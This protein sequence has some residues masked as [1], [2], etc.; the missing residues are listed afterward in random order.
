MAFAPDELAEDNR[1]SHYIN[2]YARLREGVAFER[3][4][5]E[6]EQI[7][8][9]IAAAHPD[10]NRGWTARAVPMLEAA[11]GTQ[12]GALFTLL[13]AVG[14]L[15][16][17]AC[18][19]VA[20]LLLARATSRLREFSLRA[21]LGAAP[22]RIVRQLLAESLLLA[23]LGG[24]LGVLLAHWG[25]DALLALAP[26]GMPRLPGARVD[27]AVLGAVTAV[28]LLC[29]IGFGLVPALQAARANLVEA[30]KDGARGTGEGAGR[31]SLRSALVVSEVALALT[32]L[33][34]SGLL[35]R[36]FTR[37]MTADPGFDPRGA[38]SLAVSLSPGRYDT[39]EKQQ[40]FAA[41][42]LARFA[43]LPG[44]TSAGLVQSQ[45]FTGS[46]WAFGI[47]IEGRPPVPDADLRA[48]GYYAIEGDY[49]R[50]MGMPLRRGRA[51]TAQDRAGA[52]PVAIISQT[53][54]DLEFPG[55]NPLGKR[56][57]ITN[58]N[59]PVWREV[60]GVVPDVKQSALDAAPAAQ[61]YEPFA[62][63]S[64]GSLNFVLRT[65]GA[66]ANLAAQL[67]QEIYAIDKDQPVT[68]VTPLDELIAGSLAR[69]RFLTA[70]LGLFSAL[71][72]LLA[73]IGIY[74]VVAYNVGQRT[75]EFGVRLALGALPGDVLRLVLA[76]CAR[77][78]GLG[79][80]AGLALALAAGRLLSAELYQT[81][82]YDP[83]V[84]AAI[85]GLLTLVA[86]LACLL[87]ARRATRV[88]PMQA[89][90][91]E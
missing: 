18:V 81:K 63:R 5:R 30:L 65:A 16:L 49:F 19:N 87:P 31:G 3:G 43:A 69:Q 32:L 57:N 11:V 33:V 14:A 58:G 4:A 76:R 55:E 74:G 13:G 24:G 8:A 52:P 9:Q 40:A 25:L 23:V 67:K 91:S 50:A 36:S 68:R 48:A 34:V 10:S 80:A 42:A 83:L 61:I 6:I 70:L 41:A 22:A 62:Q 29:G 73:A 12:R 45:P 38:V 89:L 2:V 21:A 17:I 37:L 44:V 77:L 1:G 72:L 39:P 15:L 90:R 27:G 66:P 71:A 7:S 54:A 51:F 26:A 84:F 86:L 53:L 85:A 46:E 60:V 78:I 59:A 75:A 35:M 47:A 82:S 79:L 64:Y 28:T 88:D 20:N 56:I